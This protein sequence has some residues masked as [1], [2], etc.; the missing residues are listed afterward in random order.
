MTDIK[1]LRAGEG[2]RH[3]V[4]RELLLVILLL[5]AFGSVTVFS[6]SYPYALSAYGD[7]TYFV[8]R[9]IFWVVVGCVGMFACAALPT[10]IHKRY[11]APIGGV[12]ALVCLVAVLM[13]GASVKRWLDLGIFSFQPSE[14]M[15]PMLILVMA[16]YM[17]RVQEKIR[18]DGI[19]RGLRIVNAASFK[20]ASLYGTFIPVLAVAFVCVLVMLENHFSGTIITFCI[21]AV[22]IFAGGSLLRWFVGAGGIMLIGVFAV[23]FGTDYASER[24][25]IWLHP[26][27]FSVR[28]ETWQITQGLIA[29]GSGGLFGCGLGKGVQKQ[30]YVSA[31]HNDFIFSIV[32]EELGLMGALTVIMLF[33]AFVLRAVRIALRSGSIFCALTAIGIAGHVGLQAFLNIGVVTGLIPNTGVTLPFFSYGGSALVVLLCECGI[34]LSVSRETERYAV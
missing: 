28:D 24:I 26:E 29:I 23:L 21:G 6:A 5:L 34:L 12:V 1:S 20:R 4:D 14:L 31:A 25:S 30:L 22:V 32:C 11:T 8:K 2:H 19:G 27:N 16:V 9:Q 18:Y 3:G 15:K 13:S 7:G 17:E 33:A 10:E